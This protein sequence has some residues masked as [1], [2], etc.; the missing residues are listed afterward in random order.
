MATTATPA[1]T[2]RPI[3]FAASKQAIRPLFMEMGVRQIV[4]DDDAHDMTFKV[5]IGAKSAYVILTVNAWDL[6]DFEVIR[7]TPRGVRKTLATVT[8]IYGDMLAEVILSTWCS[9]CTEKGW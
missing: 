6:Y 2:R 4:C 1:R 3:D 5:G 8:D 9:I 7:L